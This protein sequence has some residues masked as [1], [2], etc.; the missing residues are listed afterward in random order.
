MSSIGKKV[1]Q[2]DLFGNFVAQYSSSIEA[3]F[4]MSKNTKINICNKKE[5]FLSSGFIWVSKYYMKIPNNIMHEIKEHPHYKFMLYNKTKIYKYDLNGNFLNEYNGLKN[6]TTNITF[7]TS[8]IRCL[9]NK[10]KTSNNFIF[11]LEYYNKLPI[12][13]L[14]LHKNIRKKTIYLYDLNGNFIKK[15]ESIESLC[16]NFSNWCAKAARHSIDGNNTKKYKKHILRTDYYTK[17][18]NEIISFHLSS[19]RNISKRKKIVQYNSKGKFLKLFN[20]LIDAANEI[21]LSICSISAICNGRNKFTRDK[22]YTFRYY[23]GHTKNINIK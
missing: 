10:I 12:D 6:I 19:N 14:K 20:G 8:I 18:P 17:L 1:Y 22:N 4:L 16:L 21:G 2:Y 3:K 11:K 9:E 23:E 5:Y 15:F 13:I 7:T